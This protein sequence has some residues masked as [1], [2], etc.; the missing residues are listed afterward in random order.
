MLY[1]YEVQVSIAMNICTSQV[2]VLEHFRFCVCT[3]I[4]LSEC[5]HPGYIHMSDNVRSLLY[6]R[7]F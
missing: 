7:L 4:H 1:D 6:D 3:H 5:L 2:G